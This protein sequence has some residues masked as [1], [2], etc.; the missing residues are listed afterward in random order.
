[1]VNNTNAVMCTAKLIRA[2]YLVYEKIL[3][4][5]IGNLLF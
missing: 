2:F 4:H 1:M 5:H 3:Y